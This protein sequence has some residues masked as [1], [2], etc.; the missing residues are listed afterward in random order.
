LEVQALAVLLPAQLSYPFVA[1]RF[2]KRPALTDYNAA[3]G[4]RV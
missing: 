4:T 1:F 2:G 3:S